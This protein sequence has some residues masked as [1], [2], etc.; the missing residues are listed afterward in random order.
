MNGML[1]G[2][3]ASVALLAG[4]G[5]AL[6]QSPPQPQPPQPPADQSAKPDTQLD[7]G[8]Q[9]PAAKPPSGPVLVNGR[10]AVPGAAKDGQAVPSQFS[11][12]NAALDRLPTMAQ[13]VGLSDAEKKRVYASVASAKPVTGVTA[14]PAD[15]LPSNVALGDFPKQI[16]DEIPELQHLTFVRLPD[17]ILLVRAPNR[18]VVGEIGKDGT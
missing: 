16:R 3:A 14:K 17:K 12:R 13:P 15:A 6:A 1:R 9:Q 10:L 18:I 11:P 7:T 4:L 2:G 8:A 5:L